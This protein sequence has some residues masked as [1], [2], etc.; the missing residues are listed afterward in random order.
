MTWQRSRRHGG[1]PRTAPRHLRDHQHHLTKANPSRVTR[2]TGPRRP[3]RQ[4][5]HVSF[6]KLATGEWGLS[7]PLAMLKPGTKVTVIRR[8]GSP[9]TAIVG[10]V[11]SRRE[12]WATATMRSAVTDEA[13]T[14]D[15]AYETAITDDRK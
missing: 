11:I 9:T 12:P 10:T 5:R 6:S 14:L 13:S 8:D 15:Q 1:K 4:P 2:D 3:P 7:G